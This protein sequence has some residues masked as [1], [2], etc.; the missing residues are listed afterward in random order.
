MSVKWR[1]LLRK[2]WRDVMRQIDI[3][4]RHHE[5]QDYD[6]V[7]KEVNSRIKQLK[8]LTLIVSCLEL[9]IIQLLQVSGLIKNHR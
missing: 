1:Q 3:T 2:T 6:S 5:R 9:F 8:V 7:Y 4:L